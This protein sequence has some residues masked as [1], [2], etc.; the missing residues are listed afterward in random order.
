MNDDRTPL[1]SIVCLTYNH[2][3]YIRECLDGFLMQE[4][5]FPIEVIIHDDASTDGTTDIV[6]EYAS[7]H[8]GIIKP[9]I[10]TENQ[11]SKH[12]D[13]NT[14]MQ[15]CINQ[16]NGK[17]IA[18]CEGDDYWTDSLKLYKQIQFL[19]KE[20]DYGLCYTKVERLDVSKNRIKDKWGQPLLNKTNL[21]LINPIPTPSVVIKKKLYID[22]YKE[23]T[24]SKRNWAMGDYPLWLYTN[25]VS[26]IKYL[27]MISGVYRIITDSASHQSKIENQINFTISFKKIALFFA[28][29]YNDNEEYINIINDIIRFKLYQKHFVT[30]DRNNLKKIT[31]EIL[32]SSNNIKYKLFIILSYFIPNNLIK[33]YIINKYNSF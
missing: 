7:K 15:N 1:V 2:A 14:I 18:L 16:A 22:Y 5:D 33:K 4:T 31:N 12:H 26:N 30:N 21:L 3:P 19:E 27:D 13:F 20:P 8:P 23:I 25:Y 32:S 17:Y 11:Y 10:Q 29:R 28:N 9:I 24:P 6:K